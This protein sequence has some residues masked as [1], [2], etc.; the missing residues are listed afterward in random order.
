MKKIKQK[1]KNNFSMK[2][3]MIVILM[4]C[5]QFTFGQSTL[6]KLDLF[7]DVSLSMQART[8]SIPINLGVDDYE[9]HVKVGGVSFEGIAQPAENLKGKIISIDY[10]NN[11]F[12]VKAGSQTFYP[13]LPD[14]Q[15]IPIAN[16]ADTSN[17]AIFTVY[18]K[19]IDDGAQCKYQ[20]AFLDNLLGLRM[21]QA[22]LL[23]HLDDMWEIPK[24]KSGQYIYADSEKEMLPPDVMTNQLIEIHNALVT[25]FQKGSFHSYIFTD[26]GETVTFDMVDNQLIMQGRPYYLFTKYDKDRQYFENLTRGYIQE[27]E[28]NYGLQGNSN[29]FAALKIN[30][31]T[32]NDLYRQIKSK[33]NSQSENKGE[34][35]KSLL[36]KYWTVKDSMQYVNHRNLFVNKMKA[37]IEKSSDQNLLSLYDFCNIENS[38]G[39][40]FNIKVLNHNYPATYTSLNK[41]ADTYYKENTTGD[42]CYLLNNYYAS[43]NKIVFQTELTGL[44]RN[45]WDLIYAYNPIVY[46]ASLNT[47]QWSAFFRYVKENNPNNW[48]E[49]MKKVPTIP[50]DAPDVLTPTRFEESEDE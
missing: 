19:Q 17:K 25:L 9:F 22:D 40:Y 23:F 5:V 11:Q 33:L 47:M 46:N 26:Y 42:L 38:A 27:L 35:I 4:L 50:Y 34:Y 13:E 29:P 28:Q 49:F 36:D 39:L 6:G 48:N 14:W 30:N 10:I 12:V 43:A 15:L 21:F 8:L 24:D 3:R 20:S 2:T 31:P 7:H 37:E 44:F 32:D 16:F 1:M 41:T 45:N 18:G